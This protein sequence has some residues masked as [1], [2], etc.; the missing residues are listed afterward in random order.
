[1]KAK[2]AGRWTYSDFFNPDSRQ[3]TGMGEAALGE[4]AELT[5]AQIMAV[6][7]WAHAHD[8]SEFPPA[9]GQFQSLLAKLPRDEV[10]ALTVEQ[11]G[12]DDTWRCAFVDQ[13]GDRCQR[14][15][16]IYGGTM[17][18]NTPDQQAGEVWQCRFHAFDIVVPKDGA[19]DGRDWRDVL[20]DQVI[21]DSGASERVSGEGRKEHAAR[22][23]DGMRELISRMQETPYG[24]HE[25]VGRDA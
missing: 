12:N 6:V 21:E 4:L 17:R 10:A 16:S 13:F 25:R 8:F 19:P 18:G 22:V 7:T 3:L 24:K 15:G 9:L 5:P 11:G 2:Y 23:C 20:V 1:M 14:A